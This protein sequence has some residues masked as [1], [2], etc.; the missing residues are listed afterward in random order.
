MLRRPKRAEESWRGAIIF[1]LEIKRIPE[2]LHRGL[3]GF[4]FAPLNLRFLL[5]GAELDALLF[6]AFVYGRFY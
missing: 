5:S 3:Y 2:H 4:N 1:R 6:S